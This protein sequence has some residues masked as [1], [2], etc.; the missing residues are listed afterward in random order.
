M[1]ILYS[2][3]LAVMGRSNIPLLN[4]S[5]IIAPFEQLDSVFRQSYHRYIPNALHPVVIG[6]LLLSVFAVKV[7]LD[8]FLQ[9]EIGLCLR[10]IGNSDQFAISMAIDNRRFVVFGLGLANGIVALSGGIVAQNQG[11][12][13]VGMGT[14]MIIVALAGIIIGETLLSRFRDYLGVIKFLTLA[15]ISGTITYQLLIVFCLRLGLPPTYLKLATGI[16]VVVALS[17]RF[18]LPSDFR[19]KEMYSE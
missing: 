12:A 19:S 14:G 5:S 7:S 10:A 13:D 4:S 6:F 18:R 15:A 8:T 2:V 11:F 3:S 16:V 17:F 9:T 1:M